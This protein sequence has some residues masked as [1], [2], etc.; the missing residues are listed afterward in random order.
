MNSNQGTKCKNKRHATFAGLSCANDEI[1]NINPSRNTRKNMK[2][3][4]TKHALSQTNVFTV[5]HGDYPCHS[6]TSQSGGAPRDGRSYCSR[7][8]NASR[9]ELFLAS[10]LGSRIFKM[11]SWNPSNPIRDSGIRRRTIQT[12]IVV[13][14]WGSLGRP[15]G[16]PSETPWR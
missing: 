14:A 10:N 13:G 12:P 7:V 5:I 4:T 6:N 1:R 11:L 15:F 8:Q 16:N 9:R 3:F 2:T